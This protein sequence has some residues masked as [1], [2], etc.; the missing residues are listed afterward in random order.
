MLQVVGFCLQDLFIIP[1]FL[2]V[3]LTIFLRVLDNFL[4][5][6]VVFIL[7]CLRTLKR[8]PASLV[9]SQGL[10]TVFDKPYIFKSQPDLRLPSLH[11]LE[12]NVLGKVALRT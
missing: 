5:I 9:Q 12:N 11:L 7:I 2:F 4:L 1:C 10:P 8:H 6:R 3:V